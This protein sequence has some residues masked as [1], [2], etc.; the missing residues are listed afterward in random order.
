VY[1]IV[2]T[3]VKNLC[4]LQEVSANKYLDVH[5][6]HTKG[7]NPSLLAIM[8]GLEA[9]FPFSSAGIVIVTV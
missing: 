8:I 9:S 6:N 3:I 5:F 1:Y 2:E 7:R 4:E